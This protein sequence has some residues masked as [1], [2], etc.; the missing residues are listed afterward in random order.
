MAGIT[1]LGRNDVRRRL[2]LRIYSQISAAVAGGAVVGSERT[3]CSGMGHDRRRKRRV[4]LVAAIAL[5][6]GGYVIDGSAERSRSVVATRATP[7]SGR[8]C[9]GVIEHH[10]CPSRCRFMAR[11][12]LGDR[13]NMGWSLGLG[14]DRE[15]NPAMARRTKACRAAVVHGRGCPCNESTRVA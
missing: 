4:V 3:T 9:S 7:R 13:R 10:R 5:R 6:V 11:I 14:V 12:A 8:I 1:L 2:F 15:V